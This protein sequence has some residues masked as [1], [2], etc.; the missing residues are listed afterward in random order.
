MTHPSPLFVLFLLYIIAMLASLLAGFVG[1]A[2]TRHNGST[3]AT[4]IYTGGATFAGAL[5]L[6][7]LSL[8][9]L[10]PH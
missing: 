7:I 5:T 10:W 9:T 4:T 8:N 1:G 6:S 3:W 2:L